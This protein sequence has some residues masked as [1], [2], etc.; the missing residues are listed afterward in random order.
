MLFTNNYGGSNEMSG[1]LIKAECLT[2]TTS[3]LYLDNGNS[4]VISGQ[5]KTLR[6]IYHGDLTGIRVTFNDHL[7]MTPEHWKQIQPLLVKHDFSPTINERLKLGHQELDE[8]PRWL[9]T[10]DWGRK[11]RKQQRLIV[12]LYHPINFWKSSYDPANPDEPVIKA[13]LRDFRDGKTSRWSVTVNL[14][15]NQVDINSDV[16]DGYEY[17]V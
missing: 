10:S 9:W 12:F 14:E 17:L 16:I 7:R 13:C 15:T 1:T 5:V 3:R 11:K 6:A 8:L 4:V 2:P